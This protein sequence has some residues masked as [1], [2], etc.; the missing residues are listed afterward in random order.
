MHESE[1]GLAG[2]QRQQ[3]SSGYLWRYPKAQVGL[4]PC[5]A[6][7]HLGVWVSKSSQ[8]DYS[9][10]LVTCSVWPLH[11]DCCVQQLSLLT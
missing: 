9:S 11:Y 1:A 2:A 3:L 6:E 5:P 4:G 10:L 7:I 8:E